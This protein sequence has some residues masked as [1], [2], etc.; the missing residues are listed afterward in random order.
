MKQIVYRRLSFSSFIVHH[1]SFLL[2]SIQHSALSTHMTGKLK[3]LAWSDAVVA[4]TGFGTVSRHV[5]AELHR[6][7]RYHIDQLAI[8]YHGEFFDTT[9][10]P[11]QLSPARLLDPADAFGKAQ[12]IRALTRSDY[13][14]LWILN[15]PDV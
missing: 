14:I 7:G 6:S 1:S 10:Y 15:D 11:Y 13:D 2:L 9:K 4:A 8:N 5:L 3:V 12:L